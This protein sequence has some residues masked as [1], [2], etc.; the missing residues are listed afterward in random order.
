MEYFELYR[1][2]RG[3]AC[4]HIQEVLADNRD[5]LSTAVSRWVKVGQLI[6]LRGGWYAFPESAE[7][8]DNLRVIA[9]EV[10]KPAYISMEYALHFH[11]IMP[12]VVSSLTCVGTQKTLS[13]RMAGRDFSFRHIREDLLWGFETVRTPSG[14]YRLARPEKAILDFLYLNPQYRNEEE[15]SQ[16]RFDESFMTYDLDRA[17]L[18]AAL[19]RI[20]S[21]SLRIR[22]SR[23]LNLYK[24]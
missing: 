23:L 12:E 17:G 15:L 21:R 7:S 22:T 24:I 14:V 3:R 19:D 11:G 8:E 2:F 10:Y 9:S 1:T 16:L 5:S 20:G 4:F 6:R 18:E 13:C